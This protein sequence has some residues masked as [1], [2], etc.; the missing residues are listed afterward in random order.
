MEL[1][2]IIRIGSSPAFSAPRPNPLGLHVI[3]M[4]KEISNHRLYK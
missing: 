2:M 4:Y 3:I 1:D